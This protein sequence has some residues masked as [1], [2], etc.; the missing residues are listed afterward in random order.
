VNVKLLLDENISPLVAVRLRDD[1]VDACGIRDRGLLEATDP[2]VLER[3]FAEDRVLVTKNVAD[4][5]KLARARELHAGIVLLEAGDLR[6]NE[7]LQVVRLAIQH[8]EEA[9]ADMVNRVLRVT[10]GGSM[11]F[12]ELPPSATT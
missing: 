5:E 9:G 2:E 3:A 12:E 11:V 10:E 8:I 6:R 4:F 1:G 7:Q